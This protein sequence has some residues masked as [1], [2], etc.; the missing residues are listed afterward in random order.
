MNGAGTLAQDCLEGLVAAHGDIVVFGADRKH[1]R[2]RTLGAG[3][4]AVISGGGAGHEPMHTGF[5]GHGMLDAACTG[6]VFTSPTPDQIVSAIH[7]TDT[8]A[9]TL[10]IAPAAFTHTPRGNRP[11]GG[12]KVIAT[13]WVLFQRAEQ[14]FGQKG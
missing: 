3:K 11:V 1:V 10:L 7:E 5:V 12:D 8:G 6:Y 4:V 13:S 9:G 14:L 2:R